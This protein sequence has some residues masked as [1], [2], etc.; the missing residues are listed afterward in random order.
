MGSACM[1]PSVL[2]EPSGGNVVRWALDPPRAALVTSLG[3]RRYTR[4]EQT[5]IGVEQRHLHR[6]RTEI[7]PS[8]HGA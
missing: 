6:V 3:K 4:R 1:G 8:Q 2:I 7:G 5:P